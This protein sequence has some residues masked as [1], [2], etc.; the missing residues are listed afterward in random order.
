[1][2]INSV[3]QD[4]GL[5]C[6]DE[7]DRQLVVARYV[8]EAIGRV[9][10]KA[11]MEQKMEAMV[12]AKNHEIGRLRDKIQFYEV[13]NHEMSRRNQEVIETARRRRHTRKKRQRYLWTS[14][15]VAATIGTLA[16]VQS[17]VTGPGRSSMT[18]LG[19]K[20]DSQRIASYDLIEHSD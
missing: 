3:P 7:I 19:T 6:I 5:D 10:A 4:M 14:F 9:S 18:S 17:Y 20:T 13:V 15:A 2:I 16:I 12:E 1:M 8:A 11:E